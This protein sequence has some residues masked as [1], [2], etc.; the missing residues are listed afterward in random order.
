MYIKRELTNIVKKALDAFPAVLV[1]GPRQ[2]GKTTFLQKE[3]AG[4]YGYVSFDDP[5]QRQFAVQDANGFLDQFSGRPL[6]LDEVQYV[7][8]LF[9][10]LKIRIDADRQKH[11]Q[12]LMT[13]SQ[14][15]HLMK[16]IGDSLAGRIAILDLL[17][18]NSREIMAVDRKREIAKM[19]WYGGYPA[20]IVF[21]EQRDLWL[22]SYIRTYVERDV[23]Q[24]QSIRNILQFEQFLA[25]LAARHGQVLNVA[26]IS[27]VTGLSQPG[28][29]Q[30]I[31]LL[32][33]SYLIF[34]LKPFYK[35]FGK[36]LMKTP[37]MYFIDS[38]LAAYLSRQPSSESLWF[39]AMGG[40]FFEGFIVTEALKVLANQGKQ[41]DLYF[42][43]SS[44]GL[45]VD[46]IILADGRFY[47]IE[48]KQTATPT[49]KHAQGVISFRKITGEAQ[50][51]TGILV[52]T[53][54]Q[55][56]TMPHNVVALPWQEFSDWLRKLLSSKA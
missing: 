30:W 14:Q 51:G 3:F 15:F 43:R 54:K 53:V 21:P 26:A 2:S 49:P 34:L 40:A 17:P 31:S 45:E 33:A 10:Y 19:V 13:G 6:I 44:D 38:A 29:K 4:Q 24:L 47:P 39:G 52:C 25:I 20:N 50:C 36:R 32:E 23:R 55:K 41:P 9:S 28:C 46:L 35:N 5:L 22:S 12:F 7:P 1:T 16:N 42:W 18:F 11:G 37:K 48:I 56:T 8:E 27:R